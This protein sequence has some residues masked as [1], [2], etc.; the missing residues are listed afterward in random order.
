MVDETF[1]ESGNLKHQ[2][3]YK[4]GKADGKWTHCYKNGNVG[5]REI[6]EMVSK[7]VYI[8]LIIEIGKNGPK[9]IIKIMKEVEIGYSI[10]MMEQYMKRKIIYLR[11]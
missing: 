10:I 2:R 6:I 3:F 9:V 1:F 7:Q 5:L 8:L 11:C 4:N